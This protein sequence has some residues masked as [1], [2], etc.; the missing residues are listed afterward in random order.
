MSI[1]ISDLE[2]LLSEFPDV[3]ERLYKPLSNKRIGWES[4]SN[5]SY[6]KKNKDA[7]IWLLDNSDLILQTLSTFYQGERP[8]E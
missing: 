7:A 3:E 4:E 6:L 2:K 5:P 1:N 8:S